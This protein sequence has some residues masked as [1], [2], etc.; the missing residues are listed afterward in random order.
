MKNERNKSARV[1]HQE[2]KEWKPAV[3]LQHIKIGL[4]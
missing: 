2:K 1:A 4:L 3:D